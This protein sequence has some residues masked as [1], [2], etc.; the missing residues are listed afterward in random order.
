M[1]VRDLDLVGVA[2]LPAKADPPLIVDADAVLPRPV[3]LQRLEPIARRDPQGIEPGRGVQLR[4][5]APGHR[6]QGRRQPADVLTG[7]HAGGVLVR[8]GLNHGDI[9]TLL[10]ISG[11]RYERTG[12]LLEAQF[13]PGSRGRALGNIPRI[14]SSRKMDNA[15]ASVP[16][17]A[18]DGFAATY[19]EQHRF[20]AADICDMYRRWLGGIYARAGTYRQ[21]N[22][23]KGGIPFAAANRIP[24]L[25]DD[26]SRR[27]L[28]R[29]TPCHSAERAEMASALAETHA[30]LV[31]VH[32]FR[33]GNGRIARALSTLMA[34]QAG[35]PALDFRLIAGS[36]RN[37]YFAAI[38]AGMD[39][40][41][42]P[43]KR[44]FAETIGRSLG[45]A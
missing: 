2:V 13:E 41:Y 39:R 10:V 12:G 7:K 36:A 8:E 6:V 42:Q 5:L 34:L 14:K 15:E 29:H 11:K 24:A 26:Y 44:L 19:D 21:V 35:L 22:I 17:T 3:A 30:E 1:V 37:A 9:L 23:S 31:L 28:A 33:E 20:T 27:V 43:M 18:M 25:T 32:P 38:Q 4:E 45:A 16:K 40:N